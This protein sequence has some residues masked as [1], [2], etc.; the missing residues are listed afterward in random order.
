MILN[1]NW[2]FPDGYVMKHLDRSRGKGGGLAAICKNRCCP[3]LIH[4][5]NFSSFE[6]LSVD[7][8]SEF[9][10]V[11]FIVIYRPPKLSVSEFLDDFTVLLEQIHQCN[12]K[13]LI[14]GDFSL[15]MDM[16]NSAET[17]K[18]H[19]IIDMYGLEQ[20]Y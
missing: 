5:Y 2:L 17:L 3:K 6:H 1:V 15:H 10:K 18:F 11:K 4:G 14:T 7:I 12:D 20:T 13:L 16:I 8:V 19:E 9:G